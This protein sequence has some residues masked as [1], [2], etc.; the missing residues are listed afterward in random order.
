M[1]IHL[2]NFAATGIPAL[3]S[4]GITFLYFFLKLIY[5]FANAASGPAKGEEGHSQ[6][7][8]E[9]Q[10]QQS[11]TKRGS[12]GVEGAVHQNKGIFEKD[13]MAN[14]GVP[15]PGPYFYQEHGKTY[16]SIPVDML[17]NGSLQ[18]L[19]PLLTHP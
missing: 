6:D 1:P 19:Y 18:V 10:S 9:G 2:H 16:F 3:V 15:P 8:K 11:G 4:T 12:S 13:E 14:G 7:S 17:Q 5:Y